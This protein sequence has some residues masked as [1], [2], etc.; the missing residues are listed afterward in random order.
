MPDITTT[1]TDHTAV[2]NP[3]PTRGGTRFTPRV[4]IFET[5][6]ELVLLAELPGVKPQDVELNYEKGELSLFGRVQPLYPNRKYLVQEYDLGDFYRSFKIHE[7]IDTNRIQAEHKNG[8][9]TVHL[10]RQDSVQPRKITV[11]SE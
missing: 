6:Q 5:D 8:V 2:A 1:T 7:S 11:K 9:L 4:D 10:P 3:Q